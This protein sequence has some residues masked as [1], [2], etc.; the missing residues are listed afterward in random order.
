MSKLVLKIIDAQQL[1]LVSKRTGLSGKQIVWMYRLRCHFCT[2]R[3]LS[4]SLCTHS[5]GS[6]QMACPLWLIASLL[7]DFQAAAVTNEQVDAALQQLKELLE[8]LCRCPPG[9]N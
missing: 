7:Y 4:D 2:E 9:H 1:N 5:Q 3:K 8:G 6:C